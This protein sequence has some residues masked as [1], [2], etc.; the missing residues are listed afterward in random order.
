[1]AVDQITA[2]ADQVARAAA[3]AAAQAAAAAA[4]APTEH[5]LVV[6]QLE[7]ESFALPIAAVREVVRVPGI[8]RVP[9]APPHVRGVM[10]LRGRIV[11]VVEVRTRLGLEAA[12]PGPRSRVVIAE[13]R[14]RLLG[15]LVDAVAQVVNVSGAAISAPP[16]EIRAAG[17]GAVTGVARHGERLLLLLELERLLHDVT[18]PTMERG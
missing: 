13:V 8:T 16:E 15:L 18:D 9:Q 1:M 4:P 7:A 6:F 10:N 17:A 5:R 3:P 11:P 2:F 12:V 14:G